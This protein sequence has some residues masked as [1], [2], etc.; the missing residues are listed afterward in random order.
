MKNGLIY[1]SYAIDEY[2][3]YFHLMIDDEFVLEPI[4]H[5]NIDK[6]F[7]ELDQRG[8][9]DYDIT[10]CIIADQGA[11]DWDY[12][13]AFSERGK[14]INPGFTMD[15]SHISALLK[16]EFNMEFTFDKDANADKQLC[17]W[18]PKQN[19]Q[20]PINKNEIVDKTKKILDSADNDEEITEFAKIIL[21]KYERMYGDE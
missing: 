16:N 8:I 6:I 17:M 12:E 9:D 2:V 15:F 20:P 13:N 7:C 11:T 14:K 5:E 10:W 3:N 4:P 19:E 21:E 18:F 1:I